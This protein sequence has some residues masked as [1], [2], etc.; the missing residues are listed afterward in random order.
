MGRTLSVGII[1]AGAIA[2]A[3]HA[4]GYERAPGAEI[5]AVADANLDRAEV[6]AK[7]HGVPIVY[8]DYRE[9]L[10]RTDIDA[11][12][13][14]TPNALHAEHA[15]A[16]IQAGKHVLCELPIALGLGECRELIQMA[17]A[18]GVLL[19]PALAERFSAAHRQA[20]EIVAS[21]QIG[22][23]LFFRAS[24]A[25]PRSPAASDWRVDPAISGGGALIDLGLH[26]LDLFRFH[27]GAVSTVLADTGTLAGEAPVEDAAVCVVHG[28]GAR[29]C[30]EARWCGAVPA[31]S[32][33][34]HGTAGGVLVDAGKP[35]HV[36]GA[37]T[38][39]EPVAAPSTEGPAGIV[40][41]F[42]ACCQQAAEPEVAAEE[43]TRALELVLAAYDSARRGQPRQI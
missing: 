42:V 14:C 15:L 18:H 1:G 13:I 11:V 28:D 43:G 3:R 26:A 31:R 9:L 2:A 8:Q 41:H 36:C 20:R 30:I 27:M 21:G 39:W 17:R 40:A 4:P 23:P 29:G 25:S 34:I 10:R 7:K 35:V 6:L 19:M 24:F 32:V 37:G 38:G 22:R 12:S 33:E 5:L 16:A